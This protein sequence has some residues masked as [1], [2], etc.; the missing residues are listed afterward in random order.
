MKTVNVAAP[1][2][3]YVALPSECRT[4]LAALDVWHDVVSVFS[5][6]LTRVVHVSSKNSPLHVFSKCIRGVDI[7]R[8][9][10]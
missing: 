1:L 7:P 8:D 3:S 4:F 9:L 5:P 6:R 10:V 2:L